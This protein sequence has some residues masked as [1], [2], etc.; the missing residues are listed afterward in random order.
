MTG[1]M[2]GHVGLGLNVLKDLRKNKTN[3][4]ALSPRA[5]YTD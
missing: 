5:N 1:Q 4:V 3:S 2:D